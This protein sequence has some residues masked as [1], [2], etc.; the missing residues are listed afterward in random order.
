MLLENNK[1]KHL[2]CEISSLKNLNALNLTG[3]PIQYPPE[4]IVQK[5]CKA[6]IEFLKNDYFNSQ[7]KNGKT[8]TLIN[9][10]DMSDIRTVT[11]D[12]W[13]SDEETGFPSKQVVTRKI[14]RQ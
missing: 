12:I 14:L 10:N 1:I 3:N 13:A 8:P 5:G 7:I 11:D 9:D 6:I 4:E 2:P